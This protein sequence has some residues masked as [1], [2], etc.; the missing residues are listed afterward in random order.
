MSLFPTVGKPSVEVTSWPGREIHQQLHEIEM[1]VHVMPA[2]AAGQAGQDR[3]GSPAA[4]VANEE[5]VFAIE[6]HARRANRGDPR[7]EE[8]TSELQSPMYLVCRLLLEKKKNKEKETELQNKTQAPRNT[9][10]TNKRQ[11]STKLLATTASSR[12]LRLRELRPSSSASAN[13]N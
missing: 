10:C 11:A 7:S 1:W 4:R 13:A 8:H 6:D 5:G 9:H 3:R 2:A 12:T